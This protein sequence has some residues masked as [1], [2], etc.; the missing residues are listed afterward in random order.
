M[1]DEQ[2]TP[3][4]LARLVQAAL[5]FDA[6]QPWNRL[7]DGDVIVY[8]GIEPP[9]CYCSVMGAAGQSFGLQAFEGPG[10]LAAMNMVR[11]SGEAAADNMALFFEQNCSLVAEIVDPGDLDPLDRAVLA[12][13]RFSPSKRR[14]PQFAAMR[15]GQMRFVPTD[16]EAGRLADCL[17]AVNWMCSHG[18]GT[19]ASDPWA[20]GKNPLVR[21]DSG[22]GYRVEV[23]PEDQPPRL[24]SPPKFTAADRKRMAQMPHLP[25]GVELDCFFF[26]AIG[27]V[28]G[29][30]T[31][32]LLALLTDEAGFVVA[33]EAGAIGQEGVATVA[34]L[35]HNALM[36]GIGAMGG[37]P[38]RIIMRTPEL[39]E[40]VGALAQALGSEVW[41][42][43]KLPGL[44][45]ARDALLSAVQQRLQ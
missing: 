16:K 2:P 33:N 32:G 37:I 28:L 10:G 20:D 23:V 26:G 30:K 21:A 5:G 42:S 8:D 45:P 7:Q 27:S 13:A 39:A 29:R 24:A 18:Q 43:P 38:A 12:G 1:G 15:P 36:E 35:L 17:E 3:D 4:T 40:Q 14:V 31:A 9:R 34:D 11:R 19:L 44:D 25:A 6:L 22:G 41:V